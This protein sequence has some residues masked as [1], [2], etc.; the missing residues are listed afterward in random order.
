[1]AMLRSMLSVRL[2]ISDVDPD[3]CNWLDLRGHRVGTMQFRLSRAADLELPAFRTRVVALSEV[4][5][6]A[7]CRRRGAES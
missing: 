6:S 3:V 4:E 7:D 1:M 2:M 5:T